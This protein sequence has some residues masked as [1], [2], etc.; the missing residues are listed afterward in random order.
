MLILCGRVLVAFLDHN[1]QSRVGDIYMID[2]Y[3]AIVYIWFWLVRGCEPS[4][5]IFHANTYVDKT[6]RGSW[7]ER[8]TNC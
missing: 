2:I 6:E 1:E 5:R 4:P 7:N 3:L 8:F